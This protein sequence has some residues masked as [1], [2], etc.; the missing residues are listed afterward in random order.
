MRDFQRPKEEEEEEE[1][2]E[3]RQGTNSVLFGGDHP[4]VLA[5]MGEHG[6]GA[7]HNPWG[8]L[9]DGNGENGNHLASIHHVGGYA[10]Q[11]SNDGS[12]DVG[13][14]LGSHGKAD[15]SGGAGMGICGGDLEAMDGE[16]KDDKDGMGSRAS[17]IGSENGDDMIIDPIN[18]GSEGCK[19]DCTGSESEGERKNEG[20]ADSG[21]GSES[22]GK[23]NVDVA[24]DGGASGGMGTVKAWARVQ[25]VVTLHPN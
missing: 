7:V 18:D 24:G 6:S 17:V 12:G 3:S 11:P 22:E 25:M 13:H 8:G 14:E 9:G 19:S 4:G 5:V 21:T 16:G 2:E 10:S 20:V 23:D 1:E 15:V